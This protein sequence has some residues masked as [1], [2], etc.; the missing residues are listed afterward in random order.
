M[1]VRQR[2]THH[3][4]KHTSQR[5]RQRLVRV[6]HRAIVRSNEVRNNRE[7]RREASVAKLRSADVRRRRR[8]LGFTVVSLRFAAGS[9]W[10]I[11]DVHGR[12]WSYR[13][14]MVVSFVPVERG[15]FQVVARLRNCEC[16]R[17]GGA[18]WMVNRLTERSLLQEWFSARPDKFGNPNK[19][20]YTPPIQKS[21]K[22]STDKN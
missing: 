17:C 8:P 11:V 3:A 18:R 16:A 6:R 10:F 2:E 9:L 14:F 4:S 1:I 5:E 12:S 15:A 22:V 19:S 21:D 7:R 13:S 20:A